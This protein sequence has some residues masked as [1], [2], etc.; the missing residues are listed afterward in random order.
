MKLY[1]FSTLEIGDKVRVHFIDRPSDEF[2]ETRRRFDGVVGKV[3]SSLK[4]KCIDE[5]KVN[6]EFG[7]NE[8]N[9]KRCHFYP[10]ELEYIE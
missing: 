7:D 1:E 3:V 10:E 6:V 9:K 4:M 2:N 8:L 5:R